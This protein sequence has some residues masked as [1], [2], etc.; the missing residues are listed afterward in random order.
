[1]WKNLDDFEAD[2]NEKY[3]V[4]I[5]AADGLKDFMTFITKTQF[6]LTVD[7]SKNYLTAI[8]ADDAEIQKRVRLIGEFD[9]AL[10]EDQI[11]YFKEEED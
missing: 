6:N 4:D 9:L 7:F 1:V 5:F 10:N 2:L 11:I 3:D 8:K